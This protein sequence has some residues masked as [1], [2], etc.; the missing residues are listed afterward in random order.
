MKLWSDAFKDGAMIPPQYAFCDKDAASHVRLSDNRNPPL[1]WSDV[2][3]GTESLV[4]MVFDNDAP[5]DRADVNQDGRIVAVQAPRGTFYH[6]TL[7]DIAPGQRAIEEGAFS[8]GVTARGKS[9]RSGDGAQASARQG[10]NDYTGWFE[11]DSAMEGDYYGYDGPCPPWNDQLIHNYIFRLY[12]LD[13]P[14]LDLPARFTGDDVKKALF[15]HIL[16]EAQLIASY[17][18]NPVL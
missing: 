15:G 5:Q 16:D 10:L 1:A 7:V 9:P 17:T 6:W 13:V 18:L 2:P 4:L 3:N 12:A 14:Q 11:G 8:D